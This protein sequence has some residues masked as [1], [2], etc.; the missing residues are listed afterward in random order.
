MAFESES[1]D[2]FD[3]ADDIAFGDLVTGQI[4][5][6][7]DLDF[8]AINAASAGS[9]SLAFDSPLTTSTKYFGLGLYDAAGNN[10]GYFE[11]GSDKTY[12]LGLAAGG[13]YYVGVSATQY[14]WNAEQYG[15]T[16]TFTAGNAAGY[17]SESNDT[18][19][20]ADAITSGTEI[21]GQ[22][23]NQDFALDN[24]ATD[25]YVFAPGDVDLSWSPA[26]II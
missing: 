8:F 21:V 23:G 4:G 7:S 12:D 2:V 19:A 1:N 17:E 26:D 15:L 9:L 16:A 5:D 22:I 10:L 6:S 13:T 14:Y 20:T 25:L 18:G 24:I 3:T 11:T